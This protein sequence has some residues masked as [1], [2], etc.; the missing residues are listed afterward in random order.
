MIATGATIQG[1]AW[2]GAK[3]YDDVCD[4]TFGAGNIRRVTEEPKASSPLDRITALA[5]IDN[6][7]LPNSEPQGIRAF[8]AFPYN[9]N[10]SA[11]KW[12]GLLGAAPAP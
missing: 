8:F 6:L 12:R 10:S 2:Q 7:E 5:K 3:Y 9:K 4:D 11:F 1:F